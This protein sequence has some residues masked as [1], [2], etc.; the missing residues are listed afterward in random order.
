MSKRIYFRNFKLANF[1]YPKNCLPLWI[2]N[3]LYKKNLIEPSEIQTGSSFS[4]ENTIEKPFI[5]FDLKGNTYQEQLTGKNL[6]DYK[7]VE[8]TPN[9][10]V[11]L[12]ENGFKVEGKY[13]GKVTITGLKINTDYYLSYIR[14]NII[15]SYKAVKIFAGTTQTTEIA[16]ILN[17]ATFNT[18]ENT[19]IN[20][21]FYAASGSTTN[22]SNFTNIQLEE[23][24]TATVYEPY[25]G[26]I[27]SPNPDFPQQIKNVTG[28]ANVKIQNKNL[29]DGT[30]SE[31]GKYLRNDGATGDQSNFNI[32]NFIS[33][34][35]N[36]NYELTALFE[37][38]AT[39]G[40]VASMCE[41]DDNET[42]IK[43][44][45]YNGATV[46][47]FTTSANTKKIKISYRT[48]ASNYQLEIGS[49]ATTYVEHEEQNLPFTF[50][51]GQR[52][53]QGTTLQ[54][55]GIHNEYKQ[56][57]F[58]GSND[59]SW[60]LQSINANGIANFYIGL[61]DYSGRSQNLA[62]VNY[63]TPQTTPIAQTTEEGFYLV[64][65]K[66]LYIRIKSSTASTVAEFRTW[67]STHNLLVE[68]ELAE[69]QIIPYSE[70][71]ATQYNAIKQAKSYNDQTNISQTNDDL[72][73][74]ID[75]QYWKLKEI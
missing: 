10:T 4:L 63:F 42:F 16:L 70:T 5:K 29:F 73:F 18:G 31:E 36:T 3:F 30:Y 45:Q 21:W 7:T 13:A 6:L 20:I 51:E 75:L 43:G 46:F 35:S 55:D 2:K 64:S 60:N 52:A 66:T 32:S 54:D 37:G 26:G 58:D 38:S 62:L 41:Y 8:A 53:M 50:A 69:E 57:I 33:V 22:E 74:I 67:L 56:K 11:T 28:N 14:E 71:Q 72:P 44:T 59:E 39:L 65:V 27:P 49:T 48:D 19:T 12:I 47:A 17:P 40:G 68:Y 23:G 1:I 61:S 34:K 9:T 24:S 25:C 15:G